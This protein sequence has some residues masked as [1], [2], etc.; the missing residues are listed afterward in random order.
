MSAWD[1]IDLPWLPPAATDLKARLRALP[2]DAGRELQTLATAS[3]STA[4]QLGL[5]RALVK[6][7]RCGGTQAL[8]AAKLGIL[9]NATFDPLVPLMAVA[10]ARHGLDLE[11]VVGPFDQAVQASQDPES[12]IH[13]TDFV[14]VAFHHDGLGLGPVLDP[15]VARAAVERALARVEAIRAGIRQNSDALMLL[16]TVPR[17]SG[18]SFGSMD[19]STPGT[20]CWQV[21]RFN[22]GLRA[23]I[24]GTAD[25]MVDI[26]ALAETVGLWR[27]HDRAKWH[28]A[29][30]PFAQ[31]LAPLY[32][33]HVARVLA[34]LRG[35]S[36]KVLVLD[37]DNTVWGGVIGDDG[38]EG[39]KVGVG[40]PRGAAHVELQ[41]AALHLRCR[42]IAL[43]VCSKNTD[44]IARTPF[45]E[46][47]GMRLKEAHISVFQ[48]NWRDK[49]SNLEAI[50]TTLNVGLDALVFVD[51]NPAERAQVRQVL[52]M[53]A[54]PELPEDPSF[55]AQAVLVAGY[56]EAVQF[57]Q[58][59]RGRAEQYTQNAKR[60]ELAREIRDPEAF[61]RSLEMTAKFE[62]FDSI[63]R[64]R[65]AQLISRSNQFNLTTR[66]YTEVEVG[67]LEADEGVHTLQVRLSDAFGDNGMVSV[68]VC[69]K[70]PHAWEIDTWLMSCR[71]IGRRLE[72]MVLNHLAAAASAAGA[73]QL[74]GRYIPTERNVIVQAH[75]EKLGFELR[76]SRDG[77]SVWTLSLDT[78]A[79]LSAPILIEANG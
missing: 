42:G 53:V 56:F 54:V 33:E 13:Q 76:E 73:S 29:K 8:A 44:A 67:A 60:A 23:L 19:Q 41:E 37:L 32:A 72:W 77:E 58:N 45:R 47:P 52:P 62:P 70:Q 17:P 18:A 2:K 35:K 61:L 51:D 25:R 74:V 50:A 27:W 30:L 31:R 5:A 24:G 64:A 9:G 55:Y 22:E 40:D 14:L 3:L 7:R 39:I 71:V 69:R 79:P 26:S 43:A 1:L 4:Q 34:A 68:V 48:A 16:Q 15:E 11:V 10:G 66:R 78:F 57:T 65:I 12:P 28:W 20:M 21:E 49:A 75:Y 46:H 59:D 38:L 6:A 63:G 36:R